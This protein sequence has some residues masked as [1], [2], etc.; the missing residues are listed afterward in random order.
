MNDL[1]T[2]KFDAQG[3]VPV[4]VQDS[5]TKDVLMLGYASQEALRRTLETREGWFWSR[6]RTEL[7]RKGAT[8]GNTL[9]V[10]QV[11]L[12]CDG[13]AVI[14]RVEPAGPTCHTGAVS[15]FYNELLA[16]DATQAT[17]GPEVMLELAAVIQDRQQKR[18]EDSY[19]TY[20]FDKGVDK[21]GKK[22]GEEAAEVIIAAKNGEPTQIALEVADL[23]YHSLVMLAACNVSPAAVWQ[24]LSQRRK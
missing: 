14:Y 10:E 17:T 9:R 16:P 22:I 15:C 18:P 23:W 5:R 2:L 13:D 19:T 6:S 21:I 11:L 24:V 4:I 8:S 3:L 20:L 1:P 7:W 12:D